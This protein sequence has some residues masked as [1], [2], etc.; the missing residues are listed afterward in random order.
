M[1]RGADELMPHRPLHPFSRNG[2]SP[3]LASLPQVMFP[4]FQSLHAPSSS[5]TT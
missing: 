4:L 1:P 3:V 2:V 5:Q